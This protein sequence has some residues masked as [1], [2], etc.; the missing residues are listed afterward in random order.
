MTPKCME[1]KVSARLAFMSRVG[2]SFCFVLK[3]LRCMPMSEEAEE[4]GRGPQGASMTFVSFFMLDFGKVFT[5]LL[6]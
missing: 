1:M 2:N 4:S 5:V 6:C 3:T